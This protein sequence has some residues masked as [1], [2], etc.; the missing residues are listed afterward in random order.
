MET[1]EGVELVYG[2]KSEELVLDSAREDL[3]WFEKNK[4]IHA[5]GTSGQQWKF[6]I[7]SL[8]W[9]NDPLRIIGP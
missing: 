1:V 9:G 4:S 8:A 6:M 2:M 3:A 5:Q 7:D